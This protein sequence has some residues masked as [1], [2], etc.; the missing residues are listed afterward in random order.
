MYNRITFL[1]AASVILVAVVFL[2]EYLNQQLFT[3]ILGVVALPFVIQVRT[4]TKS[5]RFAVIAGIF[6]TIAA[7][8]PVSTMVYFAMIAMLLFLTESYFGRVNFLTIVTVILTMPLCN[9]LFDTFSFPIRLQLTAVC[10][11]IFRMAGLPV[12]TAGNTFLY[13][14]Y[15]FTV[16]PACMGLNMMISSLLTGI[17]LFGY[18]RK[19][20]RKAT[21]VWCVLAYLTVIVL[22][23]I[24]ANMVRM[25]LLVWFHVLPDNLMH[26]G[27]GI[28]CFL[29]EIVLPAWGICHFLIPKL[30]QETQED[31]SV[32]QKSR[33]ENRYLR[34]TVQTAGCVC[35]WITALQVTDKKNEESTADTNITATTGYTATSYAKGIQQFDDEDALVY[36]KRIRWFC[37]L[38]HHPMI[39]W[40]GE[41]YTMSQVQETSFSTL[42]LYTAILQKGDE[43]L[44]TAWWYGN[45]TSE[46][47]SQLHWRW[48]MLTGA[49]PYSLINVTVSDKAALEQAC[50][51]FYARHSLVKFWAESPLINS[52]GQRP[53]E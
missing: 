10:G 17:L 1:L 29:A 45:K 52:V 20:Y 7:F 18:Y 8:V 32:N 50:Q 47:I 31:A 28:I 6:M 34:L 40:R 43:Q 11:H 22:L 53:T 24:I 38:E 15:D 41:G 26:E 21:P 3:L 30:K 2:R 37:D 35:L 14:N 25:M 39:C 33:F 5:Y 16:D 19:K 49:Q 51:K 36:V 4:G 44:Y 12:E 9:Y 27:I 23:N 48:D 13:D 46:T 42:S